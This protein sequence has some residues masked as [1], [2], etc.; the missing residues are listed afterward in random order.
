MCKNLLQLNAADNFSLNS[1]I[2]LVTCCASFARFLFDLMLNRTT[3]PCLWL[4]LSVM[5]VTHHR[6]PFLPVLL[7]PRVTWATPPLCGRPAV[8]VRDRA[9]G[10][11]QRHSVR[12]DGPGQERVDGQSH[13]AQHEKVR[14]AGLRTLSKCPK[15]ASRGRNRLLLKIFRF[16]FREAAHWEDWSANATGQPYF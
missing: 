2:N 9:P 4:F 15:H 1:Q 7:F 10:A 16:K 14:S 3:R 13:H 11:G 12:Q 6:L 8:H 5:I